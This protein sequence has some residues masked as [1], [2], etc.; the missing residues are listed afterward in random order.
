MTDA[1]DNRTTE[2]LC[3]LLEERG[4]SCQ[5]H[6]LHASWYVGPKLYEA[7]DNLDGTLTVDN[8]TPEQAVTATLG[9]GTLTAEQ[10]Q[11]AIEEA[12]AELL[13]SCE[14]VGD[15][16]QRKGDVLK[17]FGKMEQA[18]ADELNATLG[19][20][21]NGDTSDGY[22]T[23][24]ELYYHR[25]ALFACL[26][27]LQPRQMAFKSWKH[28]DGTMYE[29]MFIA[30]IYTSGGWCTYHCEAKWWPLFDCYE[31]EFAPEWDG[32]TPSDAIHRLM[33]DFL[34]NQDVGGEVS[35]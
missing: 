17:A 22:H 10:V 21:I 35:E 19:G 13:E 6:Y 30:G 31:R 8:I 24:N 28:S 18:I 20:E 32:H 1:T 11:E 23:F 26:V 29:G 14:Y 5:T 12:K 9:S 34:P 2:L 4:L 3:K 27:A 16:W 15:M 7:M 25:T 33:S